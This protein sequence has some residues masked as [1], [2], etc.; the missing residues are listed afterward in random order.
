MFTAFCFLP[1]VLLERPVAEPGIGTGNSRGRRL[2]C[3]P[4][5][6]GTAIEERHSQNHLIG[7]QRISSGQITEGGVAPPVGH[8][9]VVQRRAI[10]NGEG[11]RGGVAADIFDCEGQAGGRTCTVIFTGAQH[12]DN[13]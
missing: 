13:W 7:R 4:H 11:D 8:R 9:T 12:R 3:D 2:P 6:H 10:P 5:V 1:S